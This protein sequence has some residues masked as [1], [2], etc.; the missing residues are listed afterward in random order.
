MQATPAR[1]ATGLTSVG[2][3]ITAMAPVAAGLDWS[4]KAAGVGSAF[5]LVAALDRFLVGQRAHEARANTG[6]TEALLSRQAALDN[7]TLVNRGA[8]VIA[9][10]EQ[11]TKI[12]NPEIKP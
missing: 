9:H 1:A 5:A 2:A 6:A 4:S 8:A 11:L 12:I 10:D 7:L 3:I